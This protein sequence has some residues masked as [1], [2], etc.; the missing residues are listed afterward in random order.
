MDSSSISLPIPGKE[1][2]WRIDVPMRSFQGGQSSFPQ[3]NFFLTRDHVL[4]VGYYKQLIALYEKLGVAFVERDFSYSFSLLTGSHPSRS[5]TTEMIY[6]GSSGMK[7]VSMPTKL[8]DSYL[9]KATGWSDKAFARAWTIG[10]FAVWTI[11][12]LICYLRLVWLSLP[13]TRPQGVESMSYATWTKHTRPK[14]FLAQWTG[15]DLVWADFTTTVLI[16]LFSAVCTAPEKE[17]LE[18]PVEEMLGT[19]LVFI[20][21]F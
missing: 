2:T 16:P 8:R 3:N 21:A 17:I 12:I 11:Q 1:Q 5:I 20:S 14:N 10:L 19:T 13:F 18:H 4:R 9:H 7:G 15:F 6:N